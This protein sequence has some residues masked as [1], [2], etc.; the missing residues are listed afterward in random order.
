[1]SDD[2]QLSGSAQHLAD[3]GSSSNECIVG[4]AIASLCS[5]GKEQPA[6]ITMYAEVPEHI[7]CNLRHLYCMLGSVI[8]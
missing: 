1:V 5:V 4:A 6:C 8:A 3:R 7:T 2:L